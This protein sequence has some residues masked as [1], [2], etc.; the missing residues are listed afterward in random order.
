MLSYREGVEI[1]DASCSA[2]TP[3]NYTQIRRLEVGEESAVPSW[4]GQA[5]ALRPAAEWTPCNGQVPRVNQALWSERPHKG[6]GE[7][8]D[9]PHH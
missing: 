4:A 8:S 9:A 7:A 6:W 5:E 2:L 1:R 3:E